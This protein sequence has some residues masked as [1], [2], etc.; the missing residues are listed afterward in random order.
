VI[1]SI[2]SDLDDHILPNEKKVKQRASYI[3]T[4]R[5][6]VQLPNCMGEPM[7][8]I[9]VIIVPKGHIVTIRLQNLLYTDIPKLSNRS[10]SFHS[11]VNNAR[12]GR[13]GLPGLVW[14]VRVIDDDPGEF[15]C[16]VVLVVK[17]KP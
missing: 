7:G 16:R 13:C 2:G 3:L 10:L 17:E 12:V 14:I 8:N 1:L 11:Y 9:K 5:S 6:L 15:V 4:I